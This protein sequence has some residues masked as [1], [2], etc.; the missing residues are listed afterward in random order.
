MK[1]E[2]CGHLNKSER[3]LPQNSGFH[4]IFADIARQCNEKG[5][6]MREL[7]RDEIPIECTMENIKLLFKK[8]IKGMYGHTSTK[9]LKKSGQIDEAFRDFGIILSDRSNGEIT[10]MPFPSKE[11]ENLQKM[12]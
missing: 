12:L 4:I 5:I 3:T 11:N 1:C 9:Q 2:N 8:L 7:V 6:D 10:V